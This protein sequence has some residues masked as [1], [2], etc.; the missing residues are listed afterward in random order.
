MP[1]RLAFGNTVTIRKTSLCRIIYY[2]ACIES[3]AQKSEFEVE[4]R[5]CRTSSTASQSYQ[6]TCGYL[7][8][9]LNQRF[10]QVC[11]KRLQAV[12]VAY[13]YIMT[14]SACFVFDDTN[15][16]CKRRDNRVADLQPNIRAVVIASPT[17]SEAGGYVVV[18]SS[19]LYYWEY[20]SAAVYP[21][22]VG[23]VVDFYLIRVQKFGGPRESVQFVG[24]YVEVDIYVFTESIF[25]FIFWDNFVYRRSLGLFAYVFV[26]LGSFR[27]GLFLGVIFLLFA[28]FL[29]FMLLCTVFFGFRY[30]CNRTF[31]CCRGGSSLCCYK[32]GGKKD[33]GN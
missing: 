5:T 31:P 6:L 28:T 33:N 3:I 24:R 7:L 30:T 14:V 9:Y 10:G 25:G 1:E 21:S 15:R 8:I 20:E 13:Y 11:I 26:F 4:M 19:R 18:G 27:R 29:T 17:C 12:V 32:C 2:L 23:E 22:A 16:A